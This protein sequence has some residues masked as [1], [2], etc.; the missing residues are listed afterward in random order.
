MEEMDLSTE[1]KIMVL[2][3][4]GLVVGERG[5]REWDGLGFWD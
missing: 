4:H 3:N 2:E 5:G 1:K